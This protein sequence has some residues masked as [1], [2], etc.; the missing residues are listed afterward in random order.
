MTQGSRAGVARVPEAISAPLRPQLS[1][2]DY[3][4]FHY[5]G[6]LSSFNQQH[7]LR[8]W[9][10]WAKRTA[11]NMFGPSVADRYGLKAQPLLLF[12]K[13]HAA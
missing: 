1:A 8:N 5:L 12:S 13:F 2:G 9:R 4:L 10:S 11:K 6:I 3:L 7:T